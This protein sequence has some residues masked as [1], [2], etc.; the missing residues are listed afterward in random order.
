MSTFARLQV[1]I[2]SRL[3]VLT[4]GVSVG[5]IGGASMLGYLIGL[6]GLYQWT[7]GDVGMAVNTSIA[8]ALTGIGLSTLGSSDRV[9]RVEDRGD[10]R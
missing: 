6:S 1:R 10:Q 7:A 8:L 2:A 5:G 9:W 3:T 4:C